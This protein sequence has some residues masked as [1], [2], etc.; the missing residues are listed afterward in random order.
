M[1]VIVA[2]GRVLLARRAIAEG[3][4]VWVF[5]GGKV[6]PGE[7]PEEA[8][9]REAGEEA[10]V[11]VEAVRVLGERTHPD[12][13]RQLVYVACTLVSGAARAGS[14]REVAEVAWASLSDLR[15]LVPQ[16]VHGPVQEY[17]NSALA[18]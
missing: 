13:G 15:K 11:L 18:G 2:G 12:T 17:L 8:A 6:E 10:R 4:L 16:G 1:A 5:P 7:G 3:G 14:T 9:V